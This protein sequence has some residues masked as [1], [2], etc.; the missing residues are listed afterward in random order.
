M[1]ATSQ[2]DRLSSITAI[3]V[4][5]GSRGL[6][7]RLRSFNFCMGAPSVHISNDGC[8]ILAAAP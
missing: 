6:G 7:D 5:S 8:N 3:S 1:P 4:P 2:L